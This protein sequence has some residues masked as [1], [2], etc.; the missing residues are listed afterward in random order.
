LFNRP[1]LLT[2]SRILKINIFARTIR[3]LGKIKFKPMNQASQHILYICHDGVIPPLG[4]SQVINLLLELTRG[5]EL[6]FSLVSFEKPGDLEKPAHLSTRRKLQAAG[7]DW[8]LLR[9]HRHPTGLATIFDV[10]V[11]S[12]HCLRLA[13]KHRTS[14]VHG[15]SYVSSTIAFLVKLAT[16]LPFIFDMRGF[17][18]DEKVDV[19]TIKKS[20]VAYR[21]AK[22]AEKILLRNANVIA[23]LSKAGVEEMR[24]W[25]A[26][27][28]LSPRFEV[29]TTY[30]N[31]ELFRALPQRAEQAFTVGYVGT[32]T[33]WYL[34]E[35]FFAAY[36]A[37][38]ETIPNARLLILNRYDHDFLRDKIRELGLPLTQVEIKA[39]EHDDVA[40]EM[41][42]MDCSIFFIRPSY[43]KIAS[44]PTKLGELLA[45]GIPCLT[46]GGVGDV[47][48]ILTESGAGV[49]VQGFAD[50]QIQEGV[51]KILSL[52]RAP[53]IRQ[54]CAHTAEKH[55]SLAKGALFYRKIYESLR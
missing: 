55:F 26:C 40:V 11:G 19:G 34:M 39:V 20:S 35:P 38:L 28:G 12:M 51:N 24:T 36:R 17:W 30:T 37:V 50:D 54:L 25:K 18:A 5:G 47:E 7:I 10:L 8:T 44:A 32:A 3:N 15:R 43:S 41:A 6:R 31:L 2:L 45:C 13:K 16:G 21:L 49:V 1:L 48:S 23:S 9:Y 22:S 4:Q 14:I 29:V 52:S 42:R 33:G 53:G 27:R 46:N